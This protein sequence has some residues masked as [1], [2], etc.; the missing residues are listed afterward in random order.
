MV[1]E[2]SG[3][4]YACG[5]GCQCMFPVAEGVCEIDGVIVLDEYGYKVGEMGKW[6]GILLVIVLGYR[7]LGWIVLSLRK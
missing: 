2:F 7:V 6:V 3:R 1:N 5:K 4:K